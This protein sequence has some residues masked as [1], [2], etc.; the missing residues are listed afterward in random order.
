MK[1]FMS[2]DQYGEPIQF[3][4]NGHTRFPSICGAILTLLASVIVLSYGI[5]KSIAMINFT[6]SN[7]MR[8]IEEEAVDAKEKFGWD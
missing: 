1:R 6:D 7:Y 4:L 8:K 2:I 5:N 3:A